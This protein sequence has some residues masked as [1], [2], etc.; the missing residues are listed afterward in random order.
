MRPA[1][2]AIAV[3]GP[4]DLIRQLKVDSAVIGASAIDEHGALLDSDP[5][6]V[7]LSRAVIEP[8]RR[9]FLVCDQMICRAAPV[10]INHIAQIDRFATD[11][12][13]V[14]RLPAL[15]HPAFS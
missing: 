6:E 12:L 8:A 13:A 15:E 11:R 10:R 4:V 1:D 2:E 7:D 14:D 5:L 9:L 3:S